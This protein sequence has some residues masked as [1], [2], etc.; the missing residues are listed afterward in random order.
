MNDG[1]R[2]DR[3]RQ[4]RKLRDHQQRAA[5]GV[6]GE[7]HFASIVGEYPHPE[8]AIGQEGCVGFGI[9][10]GHAEQ[11]HE[12]AGDTAYRAA[13]DSDFRAA[14]P[15]KNCPHDC[16]VYEERDALASPRNRVPFDPPES[17]L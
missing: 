12:S 10:L 8:R 11:N 9:V 14:Y 7:I 15:L 5:Y 13:V 16:V 3:I 17:L 1:R 6:Q 4:Q 2:P